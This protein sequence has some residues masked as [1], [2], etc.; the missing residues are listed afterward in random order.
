MTRWFWGGLPIQVHGLMLAS[1]LLRMAAIALLPFIPVLLP[2][3]PW[4]AN[5]IISAFLSGDLLGGLLLG[6]WADRYARRLVCM[7]SGGVILLTGT[8]FLLFGITRPWPLASL[9]FPDYRRASASLT[10]IFRPRLPRL[11]RASAIAILLPPPSC[12]GAI[13]DGF[14]LRG[15]GG[16]SDCKTFGLCRNGHHG[17]ERHHADEG[18]RQGFCVPFQPIFQANGRSELYGR[19]Q[20]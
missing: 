15:Q 19:F 9:A 3:Q 2:G 6:Y 12:W 8:L 18:R 10:R 16:R 11:A 20:T 4:T 5:L 17:V 1:A 7:I 14:G 13:S